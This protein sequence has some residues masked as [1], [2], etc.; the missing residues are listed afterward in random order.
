MTVLQ[1]RS[2][3]GSE[4]AQRI[5]DDARYEQGNDWLLIHA[6]PYLLRGAAGH[7]LGLAVRLLSLPRDLSRDTFGLGLGIAQQVAR[8]AL[9][10]ADSLLHGAANLVLIHPH[11]LLAFLLWLGRSDRPAAYHGVVDEQDD[12][13]ANHGHEH[14]VKV[15]AGNP[16]PAKRSE[17]PPADYRT[18][19]PEH[20]VQH[21]AF[22]SLVD[23]LAGNETSDETQDKPPNDRHGICSLC[24][25]GVSHLA[26]EARAL[27]HRSFVSTV[28][29][30]AGVLS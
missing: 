30:R 28:R 5:A 12:D 4:H 23:D 22:A 11:F 20:D 17:E 21:H 19:D 16:G 6:A 14:A 15:E 24:V 2:A 27:P 1:G 29:S 18:D 25:I 13:R 3:P 7:L 8:G 26:L 9:D 10:F